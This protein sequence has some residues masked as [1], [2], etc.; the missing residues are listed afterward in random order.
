ME[1]LELCFR[2]QSVFMTKDDITGLT[3]EDWFLKQIGL[4][5]KKLLSKTKF[6]KRH[7]LLIS[8]VAALLVFT[9]GC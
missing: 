6:D 9:F 4:C 2:N 7:T 3:D 1:I 8:A 5:E